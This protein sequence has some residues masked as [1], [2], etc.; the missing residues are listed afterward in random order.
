M[1]V[2]IGTSTPSTFKFGADQVSK[3]YM[4]ANSI[5]SNT[6]SILLSASPTQA[7]GYNVGSAGSR[8]VT[9][10]VVNIT[11]SGGTGGAKT[12]SVSMITGGG[13]ISVNSPSSASSSFTAT[14]TAVMNTTTTVTGTARW[15]VSDGTYS[16]T[17]DVPV[18][19]S[20]ERVEL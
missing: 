16:S 15:T 20:Y 18:E 12:Y 9:S 11:A 8:V 13:S 14:L 6:T 5:W 10:N 3:L 19:L 17:I 4:G 2:R 1:P 7:N